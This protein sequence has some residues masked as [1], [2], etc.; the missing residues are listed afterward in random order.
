MCRSCRLVLFLVLIVAALAP[1]Q[2]DVSVPSVI[3]DHMVLQQGM[4]VP[5]WGSAE[6]GESV[7]VRFAGT[8]AR[9]TA[10]EA[11]KWQVRIGPFEAGGPYV[12]RI[13]GAHNRLILRDVLIGEVWLASGQSNMQMAV[14]GVNNAAQEIA[15]ANYPSIRLLS[16]PM[17]ASWEPLS[18]TQ[19]VWV[20]CTPDTAPGFSAVAYFFGRELHKAL[21]VPVG[22]INSS[23][24]GTPAEAWTSREALEADPTLR[25]MMVERGDNAV[26]DYPAALEAYKKAHAEWETAAEKAKAEGAEVPKEPTAPA[27]PK[28]SPWTPANLFNGKISPLIPFGIR[29]VIW[30]QGESNAGRAKQYRTLF[31]TM[32]TD[33]RA[34]WGQGDFPFLF[35]QLANFMERKDEPGDSAWAEL[36]EA[37][38]MTLKLPNTGMAVTIDIGEAADIHPKNKQDVGKRLAAWA[39]GTTYGQKVAISGPLYDSMKV[40]GSKIR[41][42]FTHADGGLVA[43]GG[44]LAGFAIAGEDR[45]FVWADATIDGDTVVVSSPQVPSPVAVRYAWAD[46]PECNLYNGA[47]LPASPFRTDD[48]PGVTQ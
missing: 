6:P 21:G 1:L 19:A 42:R 27:D 47:G 43:K 14:A 32:I 18:D 26:R 37:Q 34:H 25:P 9:A 15:E 13:G 48:W 2:A 7:F 33:W 22:L 5:I 44:K 39:L 4:R 28:T 31:P 45:K 46:N 23:W 29:G 20:P 11:G 38:L 40:E 16:T 30:Y 41:L 3:G 24:G 36:R 17:I 35:V 12:M 8:E 10:N